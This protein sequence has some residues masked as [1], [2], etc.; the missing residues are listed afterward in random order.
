MAENKAAENQRKQYLKQEPSRY[1]GKETH[2]N[3]RVF[4]KVQ[5]IKKVFTMELEEER[6]KD[7]KSEIESVEQSITMLEKMVKTS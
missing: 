3:S 4:R 7:M 1:Q 5:I 2:K 6:E